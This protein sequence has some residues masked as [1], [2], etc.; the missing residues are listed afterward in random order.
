MRCMG[1]R[2]HAAWQS[3]VKAH[4]QASTPS[5]AASECVLDVGFCV[6]FWAAHAGR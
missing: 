4:P 6:A 3:L 2:Y 1:T 5:P